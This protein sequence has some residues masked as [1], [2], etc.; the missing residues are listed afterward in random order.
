MN[1]KHWGKRYDPVE[2]SIC[3]ADACMRG[4]VEIEGGKVKCS[5]HLTLRLEVARGTTQTT[6]AVSG[7]RR[8]G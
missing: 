7:F 2:E 1:Y 4:G 5:R 6:Y 8:L 3:S